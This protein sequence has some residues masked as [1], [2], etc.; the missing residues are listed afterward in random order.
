MPDGEQ[1]KDPEPGRFSKLSAHW[2]EFA[3]ASPEEHKK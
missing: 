2:K 1:D 3:D